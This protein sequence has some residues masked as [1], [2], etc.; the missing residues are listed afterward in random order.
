MN[1]TGK[2]LERLVSQIEEYFLPKNFDVKKNEKV[3][4]ED[5]VQI[6]EFDIEIRGKLGTTEINWLIECRDRPS[7][8]AAPGSWIEQLVGRKSRFNFNKVTA[9]SSTGFAEGIKVYAEK[10]GIE[11]R[12]IKEVS[13][14]DIKNWCGLSEMILWKKNIGLYKATIIIEPLMDEKVN[15]EIKKIIRKD[16]NQRFIWSYKDKIFIRPIDLFQLAIN[17][18]QYVFDN[19]EMGKQNPINVEINIK[20]NYPCCIKTKYGDVNMEGIFCY[21]YLI[22]N[23]ERKPVQKIVEYSYDGK[24]NISQTVTMLFSVD[25][26]KLELSTHKMIEDGKTIITLSKIK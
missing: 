10:E 21:G 22:K 25:N 12:T 3:F 1:N 24:E 16:P 14:N 2:Y 6:A 23:E 8:G 18:N 11:L 15:D 19:I 17:Q 4:N 26:T 9:V 20:E 5:G 13:I 7:Q